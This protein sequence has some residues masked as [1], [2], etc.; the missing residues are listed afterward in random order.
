MTSSFDPEALKKLQAK[1]ANL[2]IGGKGSARRK[3]VPKSGVSGNDTKLQTAL[4]K[5]NVQAMTGVEEVNMFLE[6]QNVLNFTAPKGKSRLGSSCNGHL[7]DITLVL[8]VHAA[9][10]ANTF[11]IY[12]RGQEKELTELVPGILPQLGPEHVAGLRRIAESYQA[13][14][15]AAGASGPDGQTQ[16]IQEADEDEVPELVDADNSKLDDVN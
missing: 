13:Q 11:A 15:A 3:V 8:S 5:L 10:G 14:Q 7:T 1:T 4:K 12:G 2:R 9:M 6:N 16:T